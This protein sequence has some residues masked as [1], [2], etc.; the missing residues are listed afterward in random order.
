[1]LPILKEMP[2]LWPKRSFD[3]WEPGTSGSAGAPFER[4]RGLQYSGIGYSAQWGRYWELPCGSQGVRVRAAQLQHRL[5]CWGYVFEE[6]VPAAAEGEEE[7]TGGDDEAE[8]RRSP[9]GKQLE[10]ERD[11][12]GLFAVGDG[13]RRAG[14]K[15]VI[16]GD[17]IS[18]HALAPL[19]LGC[20]I[21]SH[22]ATFM[23][24]EGGGGEVIAWAAILQT[25][26]QPALASRIQSLPLS[27]CMLFSHH[28]CE[29]HCCCSWLLQGWRPRAR[30]RSIRQA[31]WRARLR[32]PCMQGTWSSHTSAHDTPSYRHQTVGL[33]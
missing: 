14:R 26:T 1:M 23:K 32:R 18:S 27:I 13:A 16:L 10:A 2:T 4:Q 29:G 20:D 31:T 33:R 22:E 30:P 15:V 17:T 25:V 12:A 9:G 21:I 7:E 19:A 24:G 28:R 11:A 8:A 5:P 6:M 3:T